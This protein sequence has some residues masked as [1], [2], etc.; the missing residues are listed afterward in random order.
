MR[1]VRAERIESAFGAKKMAGT[2]DESAASHLTACH[3]HAVVHRQTIRVVLNAGSLNAFNSSDLRGVRFAC[4]AVP[5]EGNRRARLAAAQRTQRL[6][7][8]QRA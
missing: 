7:L 3:A 1:V 8:A 4:S 6:H 2:R 5:L